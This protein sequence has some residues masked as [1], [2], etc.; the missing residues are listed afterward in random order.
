MVK[1][2]ENER[3][4]NRY[5]YNDNNNNNNCIH[6]QYSVYPETSVSINIK[7]HA[8]VSCICRRKI[9]FVIFIR[10]S[11]ASMFQILE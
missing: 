7:S 5:P 9:S 2:T 4:Y 3:T 10:P 6:V 1:R 11:T 8:I